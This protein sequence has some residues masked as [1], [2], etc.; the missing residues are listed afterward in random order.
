M[1]TSFF[2]PLGE[3]GRGLV[4]LVQ[5]VV[6]VPALSHASSGLSVAAGA[7]PIEEANTATRP[8]PYRPVSSNEDRETS[9]AWIHVFQSRFISGRVNHT[10][11]GFISIFT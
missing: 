4:F 11:H 10:S 1:I 8:A 7:L 5:A 9:S 3:V 2:S 6:G